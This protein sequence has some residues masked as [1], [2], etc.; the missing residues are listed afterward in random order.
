MQFIEQIVRDIKLLRSVNIARQS[1]KEQRADLGCSQGYCGPRLVHE[2][3][4]GPS[5]NRDRRYVTES[6]VSMT[7]QI[8]A[9]SFGIIAEAAVLLLK[10]ANP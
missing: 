7:V 2:V 9:A 10:S 3:E 6:S 8:A 5:Y 1:A 4:E